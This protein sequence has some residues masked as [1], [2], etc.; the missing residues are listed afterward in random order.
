MWSLRSALAFAQGDIEIALLSRPLSVRQ[1]YVLAFANALGMR[2]IYEQLVDICSQRGLALAP[3][4]ERLGHDPDSIAAALE[5]RVSL[6]FVERLAGVLGVSAFT[7][8][9]YVFTVG[10]RAVRADNVV[11]EALRA[12]LQ[13]RYEGTQVTTKSDMASVLQRATVLTRDEWSPTSRTR[14]TAQL[15]MTVDEAARALRVSRA[16]IYKMMNNGALDF[17]VVG[18]RRRIKAATLSKLIA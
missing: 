18:G 4:C 10:E 6:Q 3:V 17:I 12:L 5:G 15:L 7:F 11:L 14:E 13:E 1:G 16:T 2:T 8:D 9:Q